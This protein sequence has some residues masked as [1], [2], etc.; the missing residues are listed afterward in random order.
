MADL[1][2]LGVSVKNKELLPILKQFFECVCIDYAEAFT[3]VSTDDEKK[4]DI[5]SSCVYFFR[6]E[7]D[8][9]FN[10]SVDFLGMISWE[11]VPN[12]VLLNKWQYE[13]S[14]ALIHKLFGDVTVGFI[15]HLHSNVSS[16]TQYISNFYDSETNLEYYK[17]V[18]HDGQGYETG[19]TTLVRTPG[20]YWIDTYNAFEDM[21]W[22]KVKEEVEE[23][24]LEKGVSVSWSEFDDKLIPADYDYEFCELCRH[25]LLDNEYLERIGTDEGEEE[26]SEKD[27]TDEVLNELL[28]AAQEKGLDLLVAYINN[29][30]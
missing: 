27:V 16:W 23:L 18:I 3:A 14:Y 13:E 5:D 7:L 6:N 29:N 1:R 22:E 9:L 25:F 2:Y 12:K 20:I 19:W 24:A 17:N 28:S 11:D 10:G 30:L 4:L 15:F 8:R 26:I 21:N